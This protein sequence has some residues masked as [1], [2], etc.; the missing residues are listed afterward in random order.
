MFGTLRS[1][2]ALNVVLLHIFNVRTI[3]NYS[4][5]AFFVLSGFLMTLIMHETYHFSVRGFKLF[6]INR[7]LRLYPVYLVIFAFSL[8]AILLFPSVNRHPD[9]HIP[10]SFMEWISNISMVYPEIIPH[11]FTPRVVPPSWALTNELFFYILISFGIS[12]NLNRTII[13]FFLSCGY[14]LFTYLFKDLPTYRYSAI[15]AASL[16]FSLGALLYFF[17]KKATLMKPSI[18]MIVA[19]YLGFILNAIYLSQINLG[20]INLGYYINLLLSLLLVFQLY[21]LHIDTKTSKIDRFIGHFSYPIYLSHFFV[22]LLYLAWFGYQSNYSS[23]KLETS[24]VLL[25]SLLLF[26]FCY[27]IV[28]LIDLPFHR[29]KKQLK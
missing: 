23:F 9:M 17:T 14:F 13:W 21:S 10:S 27:L 29:L 6:W 20:S 15:L 7:I 18:L 28:I 5:M 8:L 22:A 1:L 4:V 2:L 11:R 24:D 25:Y 12:K 3:G 19:T 16:P 26:T